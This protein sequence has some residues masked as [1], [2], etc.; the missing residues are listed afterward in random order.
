[1]NFLSIVGLLTLTYVGGCFILFV[2]LFIW[3]AHKERSDE[4]HPDDP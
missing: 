4:D 3:F 1:M 2:L